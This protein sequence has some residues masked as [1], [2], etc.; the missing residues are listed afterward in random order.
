VN[1]DTTIYKNKNTMTPQVI[2]DH[3]RSNTR[4]SHSNRFRLPTDHSDS[5]RR[6]YVNISVMTAGVVGFVAIIAYLVK[7]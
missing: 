2:I 5:Q 3:I 4:K 7:P 6:R 1:E